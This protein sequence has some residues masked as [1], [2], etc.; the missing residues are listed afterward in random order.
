MSV[1]V[2][3]SF[4]SRKY[5]PLVGLSRSQIIF[6]RVDLPLPDGHMIATNSPS[7]IDILTHLRTWIV[8]VPTV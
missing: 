4:S 8:S 2:S 1:S 7:P 3:V 5:V 6:I